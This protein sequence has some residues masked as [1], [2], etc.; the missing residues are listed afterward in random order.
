MEKQILFASGEGGYLSYRIPAVIALPGGRVI[1][2]CEGRVGGMCDYGTI[3]VLARMSE[4]GG[5]TFGPQFILAQ[6]GENTVGNPAPVYDR[7]TGAVRLLLNGNLKDGGE[8][9]I[10]RGKAPR[11]VLETVSTDGGKNWSPL[12]DLTADV[13]KKDWTWYA[14]GPGHAIQL[15]S[16]RLLVPCNHAV[17]G[18][19]E[20]SG[21][22]VSHAIYSDDHGKT[23]NLGADVGAFTNECS[24]AQLPDERVYMNMR[25]YHGKGCRAIAYSADGGQT[26]GALRL[27]EALPDPVCQGSVLYVQEADK[28]AFSNAADASRRTKLTLRL[29]ADGGE[30]WTQSVTIHDGPA[31]YSDIAALPNGKIGCLYECGEDQPYERIE[32]TILDMQEI[33]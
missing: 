16:G 31:A 15:R 4:D 26:W 5:R 33:K 21:P 25:S 10:L 8:D 30:S 24:L 29:S 7:E 1:A 6:D 18:E 13:K 17:L 12:R 20:T 14:M 11:T 9:E 19:R 2:F 28:L 22:Y 3:H 32:W 27:D 23:W